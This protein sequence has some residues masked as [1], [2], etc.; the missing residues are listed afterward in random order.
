MAMKG[1][2]NHEGHCSDH[3]FPITTIFHGIFTWLNFHSVLLSNSTPTKGNE[4]SFSTSMV[5]FT[6]FKLD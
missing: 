6:S 1:T 4:P 5:N 3:E 2:K